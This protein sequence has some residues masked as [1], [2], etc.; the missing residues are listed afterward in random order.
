M[1]RQSNWLK[2]NTLQLSAKKTTYI[3]FRPINK[4][5][6]STFTVT[7]NNQLLERVREQKLLGMWSQ[8]E[9]SW[10]AH[11][12]HLRIELAR[13]VFVLFEAMLWITGL[14]SDDVRQ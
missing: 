6:S 1:R 5:I 2:D 13:T 10:N 9:L 8:E 11:V 14:G 7:F 4:P 3:I 12:E